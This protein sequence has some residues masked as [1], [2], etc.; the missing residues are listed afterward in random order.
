MLSIGVERRP[1]CSM[2]PRLSLSVL[3]DKYDALRVT[4]T[5]LFMMSPGYRLIDFSS[6]ALHTAS[7]LSAQQ[8]GWGF[9]G[10]PGGY[11]GY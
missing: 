10:F 8:T 6:F 9:P 11:S 5:S 4:R 1:D 7:P 3:L 2:P